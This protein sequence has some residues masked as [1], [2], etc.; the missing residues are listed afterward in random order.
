MLAKAGVEA[1]HCSLRHLPVAIPL[2]KMTPG[3]QL[4][5]HIEV[6]VHSVIPTEYLGAHSA[7]AGKAMRV[8]IS[9]FT[10]EGEELLNVSRQNNNLFLEM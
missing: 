8:N 10:E 9:T 7:A 3:P 6:T 4:G 1:I 5:S 2:R